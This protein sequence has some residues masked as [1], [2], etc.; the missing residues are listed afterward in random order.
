V[1]GCVVVVVVPA[2]GAIVSAGAVVD[3]PATKVEVVLA[4]LTSVVEGSKAFCCTAVVGL[5]GRVVSSVSAVVDTTALVGD[6]EFDD[7]SDVVV[8][9]ATNVGNVFGNAT[10]PSGIETPEASS[11]P[12]DVDSSLSTI[13][14]RATGI[15]TVS[16]HLRFFAL[17]PP[18]HTEKMPF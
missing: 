13:T 8:D 18:E 1:S 6:V 5:P 12:L 17:A 7:D 15:G 16:A 10:N 14:P 9:A 4:V 3:A 11:A 2:T